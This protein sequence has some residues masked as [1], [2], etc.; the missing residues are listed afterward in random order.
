VIGVDS[1]F[2][3]FARG[4]L[5]YGTPNRTDIKVSSS[6]DSAGGW[7]MAS[8]SMSAQFSGGRAIRSRRPLN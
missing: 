4:H 1:F 2:V 7:F 5:Q 6:A 3:I 8:N